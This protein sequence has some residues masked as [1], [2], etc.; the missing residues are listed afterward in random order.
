MGFRVK[1]FGGLRGF[2]LQGF[3]GLAAEFRRCYSLRV[4]PGV[5]LA[6]LC[7][8]MRTGPSGILQGFCK[9]F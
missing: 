3:E 5:R 1:E 8:G 7:K 2:G 4:P 9:G 6:G